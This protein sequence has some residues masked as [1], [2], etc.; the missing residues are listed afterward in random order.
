LDFGE[1]EQ[2]NGVF[3]ITVEILFFKII[4]LI[5]IILNQNNLKIS[6]IQFEIKKKIDALVHGVQLL[7]SIFT[8]QNNDDSL[9]VPPSSRTIM[10]NP[11]LPILS[12]Q[13]KS[14]LG[15]RTFA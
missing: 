7:A 1:E 9:A 10:I 4:F 14:K 12:N 13:V 15:C 8:R 6:K 5:F 2:G 3:E 11:G